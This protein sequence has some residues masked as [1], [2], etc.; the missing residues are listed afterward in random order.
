M[1]TD[2]LI[3]CNPTHPTHP[4]RHP[5]QIYEIM[6]GLVV[7]MLLYYFDRK[8]GAEQRWRGAMLSG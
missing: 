4:W 8:W 6:L 3:N 5:A 2:L 1:L 7:L